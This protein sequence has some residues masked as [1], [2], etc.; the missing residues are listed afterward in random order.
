MA[1]RLEGKEHA[2][3]NSSHPRPTTAPE[4]WVLKEGDVSK[5]YD[6]DTEKAVVVFE[7]APMQV[8]NPSDQKAKD[9]SKTVQEQSKVEEAF[10]GEFTQQLLF[11]KKQMEKAKLLRVVFIKN[12]TPQNLF[13]IYFLFG[14]ASI[15]N[16]ASRERT[17]QF[18]Q[19]AV[20]HNPSEDQVRKLGYSWMVQG[21]H[22]DC[23]RGLQ[24]LD[25]ENF[26]LKP[27]EI[28]TPWMRGH[29]TI[30]LQESSLDEI[31]ECY[32]KM[33]MLNENEAHH[34][35]SMCLFQEVP[36]EEE[37]V[38]QEIKAALEIREYE[39]AVTVAKRFY[40][41]VINSK[42]ERVMQEDSESFGYFH[43]YALVQSR[44]AIELGEALEGISPKHSI[45]A[46]EII[47]KPFKPKNADNARIASPFEKYASEKILMILESQLQLAI[48]ETGHETEETSAQR[49]QL[50]R[51]RFRAFVDDW[52]ANGNDL[53]GR[54]CMYLDFHMGSSMGGKD[55]RLLQQAKVV[56]QKAGFGFDS[57][58]S[59]DTYLSVIIPMA[60]EIYR[61]RQLVNT[62]GL[63]AGNGQQ[64]KKGAKNSK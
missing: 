6:K 30:K 4:G 60:N 17:K 9:E 34:F 48:P 42:I 64:D 41:M 33:K 58:D 39:K 56:S 50:I 63:E 62:H 31:F 32:V 49:E 11:D 7:R 59:T 61:L 36:A 22:S 44:I 20:R 24:V 29:N 40:E 25:L 23:Y 51:K 5:L 15:K 10:A 12:K 43:P 13:S 57:L 26:I 47:T 52:E 28:L 46:F 18:L 21:D 55:S 19:S 16:I 14:D 27:D 8:A 2:E 45:E 53:F 38:R 54:A 35:Q 1:A 3:I 37:Q